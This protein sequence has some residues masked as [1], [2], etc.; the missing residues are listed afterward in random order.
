MNKSPLKFVTKFVD[1]FKAYPLWWILGLSLIVRIIYLLINY[2]LW[3]DSY[4]YIGM[5]KYIF[6]GG[7]IGMWESFRPL[8]HPLILGV[9]WKLK[10]DV[11]ITDWTKLKNF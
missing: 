2:P 1:Y 9:L 7:K 8:I 11:I 3:W 10:L 5:G 6:S 4:V